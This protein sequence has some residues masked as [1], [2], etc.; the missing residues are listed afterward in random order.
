M[1]SDDKGNHEINPWKLN[2]SP[3]ASKNTQK[4]NKQNQINN[5]KQSGYTCYF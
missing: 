1:Q 2:C 4:N 5:N 3:N